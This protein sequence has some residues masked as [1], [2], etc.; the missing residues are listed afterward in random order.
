MDTDK[1]IPIIQKKL[2]KTMLDKGNPDCWKELATF[3]RLFGVNFEEMTRGDKYE[4]PLMFSSGQESK[5]R[6]YV[7]EG[8]GGRKDKRYNIPAKDLKAHAE[9]G[10]IISFSFTIK[11]DNHL[12]LFC[13]INQ[14]QVALTENCYLE[15]PTNFNP[16][17]AVLM[18]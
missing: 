9:V 13:N 8:S 7:V 2:T 5:I 6:F 11:E 17:K 3:A 15:V 16:I 10:D 1:L 14:E 18:K 4:L 12:M